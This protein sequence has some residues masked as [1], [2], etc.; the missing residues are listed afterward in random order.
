MWWLRRLLRRLRRGA[1]E[2]DAARIHARFSSQFGISFDDPTILKTALTHRSQLNSEASEVSNERLEF[3]GDSVLGLITSDYLFRSMDEA[4]EGD[5]TK[6]RSRIVNKHVLGRIG[7]RLGLLDLLLYAKDEIRGDERAL[8]T[9]SADAL[10]AV[11]GAIY[12][13]RGFSAAC[14]FVID[15][16]VDPLSEESSGHESVDHKSMLQELCQARFKVHPDYR[17]VARL[18]PEHRK[19]FRVEVRIRGETYGLGKGRSRKEA[20]QAAAG[21]AIWNL[22]GKADSPA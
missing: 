2:E 17:I 5:L 13:D 21:Q 16:I 3:L 7:T 12:L 6:A 1:A 15:H 19:I 8:L 10:E 14:C 22:S 20:E 11:V 18:G 9:L 4:S